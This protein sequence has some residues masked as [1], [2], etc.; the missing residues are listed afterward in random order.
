LGIALLAVTFCGAAWAQTNGSITGTVKDPSGAAIAGATV[1]VAS[2]DRGINRQMVTNST[3]E[4]NESALPSG[5][6]NVIVS[7]AGFKKYE[8]KGVTLD[9]ARRPAST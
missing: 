9:V 1:V 2:P 8:A 6:Y 7:A 5:K 4:Y 3:G